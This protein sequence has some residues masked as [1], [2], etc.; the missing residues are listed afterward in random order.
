[1]SILLR[2]SVLFGLMV[3]LTSSIKQPIPS[4]SGLWSEHWVDSDVDYVDTLR[5]SQKNDSLFISLHNTQ[6]DWEPNF[7]KVKFDG[8]LLTFQMDANNITNFFSFKL[9]DDQKKFEGKVH[10]WR[11][12]IRKIFLMKVGS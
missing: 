4:I 8:S 11:G 6:V 2:F 10:T 9:S 1:M 5:L 12:E 3:A 7:L